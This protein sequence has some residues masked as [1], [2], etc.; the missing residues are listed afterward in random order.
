MA[1]LKI[2]TDKLLAPNQLNTINIG[3]TKQLLKEVKQAYEGDKLATKWMKEERKLLL[4]YMG[5]YYLLKS[6]V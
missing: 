4:I 5:N 3:L 6:K 2:N 1:I